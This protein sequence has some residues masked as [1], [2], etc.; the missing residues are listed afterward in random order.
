MKS[1][2]CL[3]TNSSLVSQAAG[4]VCSHLF[5]GHTAAHG[6][7]SQAAAEANTGNVS[8][9]PQTAAHHYP[10]VSQSKADRL[11]QNGIY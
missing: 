11:M 3:S 2:A 8:Q 1:V 10:T 9:A 7:S 4:H 6:V 5:T